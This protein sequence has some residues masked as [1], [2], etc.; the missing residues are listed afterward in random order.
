MYGLVECSPGSSELLLAAS[1]DLT[2]RL[3]GDEIETPVIVF[4]V[5]DEH[6][7]SRD[8]LAT[9]NVGRVVGTPPRMNAV[10]LVKSES[11]RIYM[12]GGRS[13]T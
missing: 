6:E 12:K 2:D 10:V 13:R 3:T 1:R 9:R 5:F 7:I 8:S 4:S 11:K